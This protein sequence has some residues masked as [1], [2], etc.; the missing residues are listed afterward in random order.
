[1]GNTQSGYSE[2][3]RGNGFYQSG[4]RSGGDHP[5][6]IRSDAGYTFV[7][8]G[9]P[10]GRRSYDPYH[11]SR[12]R[13]D[14]MFDRDDGNSR[15]RG[16]HGRSSAHVPP[17]APMPPNWNDREYA[18]GYDPFYSGRRPDRRHYRTEFSFFPD[19]PPCAPRGVVLNPHERYGPFMSGG[20]GR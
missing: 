17:R 12:R 6:H 1:M 20:R 5:R 10:Y 8:H 14:D 4:W 11:P 3:R 9:P 15:R 7:R 2:I 16:R 13:Y 19:L 18:G